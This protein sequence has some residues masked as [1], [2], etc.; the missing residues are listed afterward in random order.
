MPDAVMIFAA[1]FGT[2]MRPLTDE[3]PKPLV[4][5]AGRPMID[6][7]IDLARGAGASRLVANIH[8]KGHMLRDHLKGT[9][10]VLVEESPDVL[11]TGG[12]LRHALPQLGPG[13]VWTLNPDAVWQ[14]PNPLSLAAEQWEPDRMDALLVCLTPAQVRGRVGKGDFHVEANGQ[15]ARGGDAIYGGVQIL[16]TDRLAE[17]AEAT[18]SLNRL[19]DLLI[20]D[21]RC[22][23]CM[24]PGRWCD[25]GHP[26]ALNIAEKMLGESDHV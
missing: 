23:A 18:F 7:A 6:H 20:A 12:G 14:G 4:E 9:G 3:R 22:F 11:D 25:V 8:Y 24:Y 1:G 15:I 19:W 21:G 16:K 26:E 13:P 17:I 5:L 10:V 2:R